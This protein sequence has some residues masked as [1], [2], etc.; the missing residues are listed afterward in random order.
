MIVASD[1]L[2]DIVPDGQKAYDLIKNIKNTTD[3]TKL[4]MKTAVPPKNNTCSDNVTI[5]VVSLV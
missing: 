1:G 2:W 3:A 4:L 5:C